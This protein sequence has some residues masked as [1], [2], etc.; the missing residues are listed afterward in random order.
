MRY[1]QCWSGAD[2]RR[3]AEK[4]GGVVVFHRFRLGGAARGQP[5]ANTPPK[6][7][8][9]YLT[10]SLDASTTGSVSGALVQLCGRVS[11]PVVWCRSWRLFAPL[12][13]LRG[14]WRPQEPFQVALKEGRM[15]GSVHDFENLQINFLAAQILKPA[16]L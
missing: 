13:F 7:G 5:S 10:Q 8:R 6:R 16:D 2:R 11:V 14:S 3:R 15:Q 4:L 1:L 9:A 12:L